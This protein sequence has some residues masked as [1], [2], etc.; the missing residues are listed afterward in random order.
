MFLFLMMKLAMSKGFTLL[1]T[2]LSVALI[3]IISA[4]GIPILRSYYVDN[5]LNLAALSF[6]Q[7]LHHAQQLARSGY[8][9]GSWGV[10]AT[11]GS[12]I[13]YKGNTYPTRDSDFD[14]ITSIDSSIVVTGIDEISFA[15]FTAIPSATGTATLTSNDGQSRTVT[16]SDQGA[17]SL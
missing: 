5:G 9:D 15:A 17:V 6:A 3:G 10:H 16:I 14:E 2:L 4:I 11:S 8:Y 7:S 13:L 1:E 12:L